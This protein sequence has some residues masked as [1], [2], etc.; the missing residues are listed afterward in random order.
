M[1]THPWGSRQDNFPM[2][3]FPVINFRQ[4]ENFPL[5]ALGAMGVMGRLGHHFDRGRM[6]ALGAFQDQ[7]DRPIGDREVGLMLHHPL[8]TMVLLANDRG[9]GMLLQCHVNTH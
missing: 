2:A 8:H 4:D 5:G 9:V 3:V 1:E 7:E 6:E